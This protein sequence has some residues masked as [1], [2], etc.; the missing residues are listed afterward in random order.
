MP[1]A[2]D[3]VKLWCK[4]IEKMIKTGTGKLFGTDWVFAK[5]T[6]DL[7]IELASYFNIMV[8]SYVM[9]VTLLFCVL[10]MIVVAAS[11]L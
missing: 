7:S 11:R 2:A 1:D 4:F 8:L 5:P 10:S 3:D 6:S 9:L